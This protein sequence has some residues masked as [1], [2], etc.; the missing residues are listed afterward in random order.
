MTRAMFDAGVATAS[1]TH[2]IDT[3]AASRE[4]AGLM[5]VRRST[6]LLRVQRTTFSRDGRPIEHSDDR[7][8][9]DT[10]SFTI[11]S[12]SSSV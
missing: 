6:R 4:D 10:I 1:G 3:I 11:H 9:P 7:Y 12:T 8:A 5:G 2:R